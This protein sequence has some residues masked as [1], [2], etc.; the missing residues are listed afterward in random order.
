MTEDVLGRTTTSLTT[1]TQAYSFVIDPTPEQA[2]ALRS[3]V[4]GSRYAYNA[5]LGLVAAN[6]DENREKKAG[7]LE[8][9]KDDYLSTS[10][11]GLLYLWAAKRDELAPWWAENGSSTY[12]D[13]AQRLAK[14]FTNFRK[15]RA[16]FP[17]F[18]RRGQGGSVRFK[19]TAVRLSDAHHV[20]ISRIGEVKTY[21]STRK[22][23]RHLDRGTGRIVA[24]TVSERGGTWSVAFTV[25]VQRRVCATRAPAR[26]IGIDVGLTALYT[27]ATPDGKQVLQVVNP[28]H[29]QHSGQRLAHAQRIAARRQGP[30]PGQAPSIRW[31]RANTRVQ[32]IHSNVANARRNLIHET[33]TMLAKDYDVIVVEDLNVAGMLK[34]HS[35]AKHISDAAWGEFIRQLE[36]KTT[37]YGST[38]VRAGRFYPSSKTCSQC[39][40]VKAKLSLEMRMFDCEACG[41]AMDR[42]VN[43]AINLAR[44]GLPGT[45]SGTGRGGEVRPVASTEPAHPDEASTETPTLVRA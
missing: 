36:Y 20:R 40:T 2:N 41:L 13:A 42:D 39:G 16:K 44:L 10:H 32:K 11:F 14:A 33:T 23:F 31:K 3:H 8:V 35:L 12:N 22:L 28:R 25:E 18:K 4:G 24:A 6:W 17:T 45:S 9:T 29:L 7:G 26:V 27:G 1:V 34:N 37:W 43:A 15:G 5:L 38:L 30:R 21:E 19:N